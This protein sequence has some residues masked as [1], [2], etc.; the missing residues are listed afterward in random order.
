MSKRVVCI[1]A[2]RDGGNTQRAAEVFTGAALKAGAVVKTFALRKLHYSGCLGCMACKNGRSETCVIQDDLTEALREIAAGDIT[3][4]ASP[5]YIGD[6]CGQLKLLFDRMYS[7]F[8]P[9]Y[10]DYQPDFVSYRPGIKI[11][12]RASRLNPGKQIVFISLHG[13]DQ[14]NAFADIFDRYEPFWN[15]L[16]FSRAHLLRSGSVKGVGGFTESH[17]MVEELKI[18]ARQLCG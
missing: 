1:L 15:W 11:D 16:G 10:K 4:F 8:S 12:Q 7:F 18:L 17:P 6:V 14:K 2:G 13:L 3:I 9:A 5:V